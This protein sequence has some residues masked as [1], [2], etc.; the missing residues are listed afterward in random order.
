[1]LDRRKLMIGAAAL[2]VAQASVRAATSFEWQTITPAEAGF[3]PDF[4][5]RLDQFIVSWQRNI[6]G[7]IVLRRGRVV[8]RNTTKGTMWFAP[9]R[10]GRRQ[11]ASPS[12]PNEA[13]RYAR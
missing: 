4:A 7:M 3:A 10:G 8:S 5:T 1:M 6:H 12:R 13:T 2:G 11:T 9:P